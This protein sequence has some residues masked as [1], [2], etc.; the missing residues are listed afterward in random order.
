MLCAD[1]LGSEVGAAT[2]PILD[3]KLLAE[4]FRQPLCSQ[5]GDDVRCT[6]RAEANDN[7]H[8]SRGI[9]VRP[10]DPRHGRECG[11]AYCQIQELAAGKFHSHPPE[12][13]GSA[14][15]LSEHD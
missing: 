7:V 4:P 11:G 3:D 14:I 5:A 12:I 6:P 1:C 15:R 10:C 2:R 8:R 9:G 13:R